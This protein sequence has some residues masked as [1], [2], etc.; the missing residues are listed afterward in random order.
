M[1]KIISA[2]V[3]AWRNYESG[4]K[5]I[6][7]LH[8]HYPDADIFINVDYEG[9]VENYKKVAERNNATLTINNFQVGYCGD[10]GD[11][12]VGKECWTREET[13]EWIRGL[14]EAC[15]KTDSKYMMI[16]EEDNF[17]I[18]PLSILDR[19]FSMAIHANINYVTGQFRPNHI[20]NEFVL[21]SHNL[22]GTGYAPGYGA[23]G[24]CIFKPDEF[25]KSWEKC[26][27]HLWRDYDYLRSI[28]KIIGWEDFV[29]QFVMMIGGYEINEN[30][31]NAIPQED[32]KW[33]DGKNF[34][35]EDYDMICGLKDHTMIKL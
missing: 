17:I 32:P 33:M 7:S 16:L 1:K 15:K 6:K 9:D 12:I 35:G 2:Y 34:R 30:F 18:R 27:N 14:Y 29:V 28:N 5:S 19:D 20:P 8:R 31:W 24:G 10:F 23:G 4:E 13:F 3:W 22:G 26:R 21:Y 11:V 25:V